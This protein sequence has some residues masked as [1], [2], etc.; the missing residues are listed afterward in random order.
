MGLVRGALFTTCLL[1]FAVQG[2][3]TNV[4]VRG[5]RGES[6]MLRALGEVK[7]ELAFIPFGN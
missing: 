1:L 6:R 3:H 4:D 2:A 7:S 5:R